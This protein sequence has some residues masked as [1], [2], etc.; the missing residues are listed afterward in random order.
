MAGKQ[1]LAS[2]VHVPTPSTTSRVPASATII[3]T[4]GVDEFFNDADRV[5]LAPRAPEN[6]VAAQLDE[7]TVASMTVSLEFEEEARRSKGMESIDIPDVFSPTLSGS[8]H[9]PAL[10]SC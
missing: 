2:L 7:V 10:L 4:D 9:S 6:G 5:L 8:C 3:A 1:R